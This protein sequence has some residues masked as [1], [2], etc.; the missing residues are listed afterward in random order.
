MGEP[1]KHCSFDISRRRAYG[2]LSRGCSLP[3][4]QGEWPFLPKD[5]LTSIYEPDVLKPNPKYFDHCDF[6]SWRFDDLQYIDADWYVQVVDY[7]ASVGIRLA[8]QPVWGSYVA[9]VYH[10]IEHWFDDK[11][12]AYHFGKFCGERYPY[13]PYLVGGDVHRYWFDD[14]A[15]NS[16]VGKPIKAPLVDVIDYGPVFEGFANGITRGEEKHRS[17]GSKPLITFHPLAR[18]LPDTPKPLASHMFPT[19]PWLMI[20]GIQSGHACKRTFL[21]PE[22][23]SFGEMNTFLAQN[24]VD[25]VREMYETSTKDGSLRPVIDLEAHYESE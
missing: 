9:G 8:I 25:Y 16:R 6:V 20:D 23:E 14:A 1:Y 13:L 18:W 3:N 24:S 7:A 22:N 5:G 19:S 21:K 4:R 11:D 2:K 10:R 17:D 12:A 15:F